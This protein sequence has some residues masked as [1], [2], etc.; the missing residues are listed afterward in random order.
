MEPRRKRGSEWVGAG[1]PFE[2]A[3][4]GLVKLFAFTSDHLQR[5]IAN[6]PGGQL[7]ARIGLMVPQVISLVAERR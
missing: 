4:L 5:M 6:N 3:N 1:V 7:T 2:V